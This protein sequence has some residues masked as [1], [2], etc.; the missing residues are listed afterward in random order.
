MYD[1][2]HVVLISAQTRQP[3]LTTRNGGEAAMSMTATTASAAISLILGQQQALQRRA[4]PIAVTSCEV[5]VRAEP[6]LAT[7]W[8]AKLEEP[9]NALVQVE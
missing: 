3:P 1:I 6:R 4:G 7:S 9:S 5:C 8:L 2:L